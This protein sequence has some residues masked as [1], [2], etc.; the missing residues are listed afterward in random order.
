MKD[1]KKI[2]ELL[3]IEELST[4]DQN[5]LEGGGTK[6][7]KKETVRGDGDTTIGSGNDVDV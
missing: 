2:S 1:L 5:A 6:K 4:F 7:K 3:E